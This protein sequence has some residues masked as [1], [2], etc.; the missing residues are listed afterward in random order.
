MDEKLFMEYAKFEAKLKE[1]ER[2]RAIYKFALD[3]MPRARSVNLHKAFTQFEKQYGDR[4]GIEDVI[5]SKRRVH[6]EEQVKENPKVSTV[7]AHIQ[8]ET[9]P[10]TVPLQLEL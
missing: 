5:L 10:L 8:N 9:S 2:A 7:P 4:D 1:I 3:R 6:Y